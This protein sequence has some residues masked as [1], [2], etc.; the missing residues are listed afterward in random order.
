MRSALDAINYPGTGS[1]EWEGWSWGWPHHPQWVLA[2]TVADGQS[3]CALSANDRHL[4]VAV[5]IESHPENLNAGRN[6]GAKNGDLTS[7]WE[8][9]LPGLKLLDFFKPQ[10]VPHPGR[11]TLRVQWDDL[12]LGDISRM[13]FIRFDFSI[14]PKQVS[15]REGRE[16]DTQSVY[17]KAGDDPGLTGC[18]GIVLILVLLSFV[19]LS[20]ISPW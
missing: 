17:T 2:F 16:P 12:G 15:T 19:Y 5:H 3:Q 18:L 6:A 13:G 7:V 1:R 4:V 11:P 8:F 10:V 9:Q 14:I 20:L